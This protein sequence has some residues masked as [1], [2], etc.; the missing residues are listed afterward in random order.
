MHFLESQHYKLGAAPPASKW[1][2]IAATAAPLASFTSRERQQLSL[3][4]AWQ[5]RIRHF[6][7][8]GPGIVGASLDMPAATAMLLNLCIRK[9]T[10]SGYEVVKDDPVLTALLQ[11]WRGDSMDQ[12]MLFSRLIRTLDGPAECY[13]IL[14]NADRR[15]GQGRLYWQLAQTTNVSDNRDGTTTIRGLPHARPGD[16]YH[17]VVNNRWVYHAM[18]SDLEWEGQA[19]SAL[20]RGLP[21]IEQYKAAMR[22]ISRDLDSALAMNGVMWAKA[23]GQATGW[24]DAFQAWAQRGITSD[25]GVESVVPFPMTTAEK[26]EWIEVGRSADGAAIEVANLFLKAF[27]QSTDLP[28]SMLLEGPGQAGNHWSA[29]LEGDFYADMTMAPRWARACS[30]IT[31]TH[32]RPLMRGLPQ[33]TGGLNPDDYEVWA[34]D[35]R[36]RTRTDNTER[37]LRAREMGVATTEAVA[38]A[39]GLSSDQVMERPEGVSDYE[40]WLISSGRTRQ[41]DAPTEEDEPPAEPGDDDEGGGGPEANGVGTGTLIPGEVRDPGEPNIV[42]SILTVQRALNSGGPTPPGGGAPD[43]SVQAAI[44]EVEGELRSRRPEYWNELVPTGADRR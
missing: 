15:V 4:A 3:D 11:M 6:D 8:V 13:L 25:D 5:S 42:D 44:I 23:V 38:E 32:L 14:H 39:V 9:R 41:S 21:H 29:Y 2:T 35:V 37:V 7:R 12:R 30:I 22:R 26:P 19:W 27:A 24:V 17:Q 36:I 1:D 31:E 34:D 20:R 40:G 16:K 10:A 18:N 28:T 33:T 43:P